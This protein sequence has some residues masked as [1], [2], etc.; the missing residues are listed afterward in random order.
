[1]SNPIGNL[2]LSMD[3]PSVSLAGA[4]SGPSSQLN[5]NSNTVRG[6]RSRVTRCRFVSEIEMLV[7]ITPGPTHQ[8]IRPNLGL[9]GSDALML[10]KFSS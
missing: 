6:I 10:Y 3:F 9:F 8:H 4:G 1:M 5:Q 7:E 2:V